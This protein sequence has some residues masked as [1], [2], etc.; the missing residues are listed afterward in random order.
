L[1]R[2]QARLYQ[3]GLRIG[4][5]EFLAVG[6]FAGAL[7]GAALLLLGFVT[8]GLLALAGGP[9]AYY[10]FLMGRR[11]RALRALR[12]ALP[13]AIDDCADH[14][15]TYNNVARA[16]QEL[17]AKGPKPLRPTFE[18]VLALTHGGVPVQRAL[19]EAAASREEVFLR[20]FLDTLANAEAK[21]GDVKV[22]LERL[23]KAQRAQSRMQRRITAAQAGGRLVGAVYG[24][25]PAVFLVF[26]RLFGGEAYGSFYRSALGQVV[27][28]LV[29]LSGA[30]TWWAT[31]KIAGRGIYLH[32]QLGVRD[33]TLAQPSL[34]GGRNVRKEG[35]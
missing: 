35:Q 8:L 3:S 11:R 26:I 10:A 16:L 31:R 4:V 33:E 18:G 24:A 20:Q 13:D 28:A 19:R 27:Q 32:E 12:D 1:D 25:A 5:L 29:V 7:A 2:L 6:L 23:A 22:V 17:A 21:G 15:E 14:L 9:L 30:L 34:A